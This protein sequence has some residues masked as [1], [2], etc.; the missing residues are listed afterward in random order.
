[1]F[2]LSY[3]IPC[4]WA[5]L[6]GNIVRNSLS[7]NDKYVFSPPLLILKNLNFVFLLLLFVFGFLIYSLLYQDNLCQLQQSDKLSRDEIH[8]KTCRMGSCKHRLYHHQNSVLEISVD[9]IQINSQSSKGQGLNKRQ[10]A[11]R[12]RGRRSPIL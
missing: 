1:M 10:K 5:M 4:T 12:D 6:F 2:K 9:Y 3:F 11:N 8:R 7:S